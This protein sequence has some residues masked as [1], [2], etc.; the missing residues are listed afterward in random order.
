MLSHEDRRRLAAIE[1]QMLDD[2]P[3]FVRRFRRRTAVSIRVQRVL[4]AFRGGTLWLLWVLTG[5]GATMALIG[6]LAVAAEFVLTGVAL[7]VVA[8]WSLRWL[9]RRRR[10][11]R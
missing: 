9:R 3:D 5:V 2:D 1:R 7:A 6:V 8:G 10:P 4:G 11:A